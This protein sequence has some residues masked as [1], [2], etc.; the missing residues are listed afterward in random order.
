[1]KSDWDQ[2]EGRNV[3]IEALRRERRRVHRVF[4]D[5][6]ARNH[7]KITEIK[8]LIH[9]RSASLKMVPRAHLDKMSR[10]GVHNGVIAHA[11]KL[12]SWSTSQLLDDLFERGLQPFLLLADE[13]Q[14]EYNL[15]AVLRSAMGAGVHGVIVPVKRGKG[16][17]EVVQRVSMGGAEE[18]PLIREGLSSALSHI[19]RAGI[20]VIG[21]DMDGKRIWDVTLRGSCAMVLGGESKGLSPTLRKKCDVIAS[22]PLARGLDSLNVSVTAGIMMFEKCRQDALDI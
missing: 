6:R 13:L 18:V 15:G 4:L 10:T 8:S 3:V 17:T 20:P 12:P 14:Y 16:L 9:Q 11:D 7:P 1:M 21:A 22:V 5:D 2:L 19:K